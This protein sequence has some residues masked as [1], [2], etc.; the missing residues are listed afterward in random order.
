[1][2]RVE[3]LQNLNKAFA[4]VVKDLAEQYTLGYYPADQARDGSYR[5]LHVEVNRPD[6]VVTTRAGYRAPAK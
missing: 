2:Y 4:Q 3:S 1:L 6:V 5:K